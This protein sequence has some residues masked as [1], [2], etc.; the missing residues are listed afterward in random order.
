MISWK[1]LLIGAS[2][3]L[4]FASPAKA[5]DCP[6]I[7]SDAAPLAFTGNLYESTQIDLD[8]CVPGYA[9]LPYS[10][11]LAAAFDADEARAEANDDPIGRL[12]FD[13]VVDGQD[14]LITDVQVKEQTLYGAGPN[15][16]ERKVITARFKN[17]DMPVV[18]DY[19]WVK[20]DGAWAVDEVV[21]RQSI[22]GQGW[23]LSLLLDYG[24]YG[25]EG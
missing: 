4:M 25:D 13:F 8:A 14:A 17:F 21:A 12:G 9:R 23:V 20:E 2:A 15:D 19:Y 3:A 7:A 1:P 18:L 22:G 24:F 16:P 6:L 10:K 11:R 5:E